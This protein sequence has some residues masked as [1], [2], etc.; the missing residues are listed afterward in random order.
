MSTL[1]KQRC[2][3]HSVR[4]AVARCPLCTQYFCR[5]CVTEHEDRVICAACLR[6]LTFK[7][8]AKKRNLAGVKR[9]MAGACGF[10]LAWMMFYTAG[11][12]LLSIPAEFHDGSVWK[13]STFD[14]E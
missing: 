5:E 11:R 14:Q 4:E 1:Q 12:M 13:L 8:A 6:R 3:N 7:P 10:L 9:L 2:L